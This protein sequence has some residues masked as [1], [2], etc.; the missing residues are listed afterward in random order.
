MTIR[1]ASEGRS[2]VAVDVAVSQQFFGWVFGLGSDVKI[3]SPDNV[4]A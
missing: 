3:T 1:P 4:V 2:F